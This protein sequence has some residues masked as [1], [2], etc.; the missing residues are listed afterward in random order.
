V[1]RSFRPGDEQALRIIH[2]ASITRVGPLVYNPAQVAAWAGKTRE[3]WEWLEWHHYGD[4]ITIAFSPAGEPAAFALLE[5]DGHLDML[6]CHP[7]HVRQGHAL[8]LVK[9]ASAFARSAGLSMITTDAS[10]LARPVFLAAGYRVEQRQDFLLDG[11]PIHNYAMCK[12]L[13]PE[14]E[15]VRAED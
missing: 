6:Y 11:V 14:T 15:L 5:A 4:R 7:D 2:L 12:D 10:E 9:E 1:I 3:A 8:R 13:A